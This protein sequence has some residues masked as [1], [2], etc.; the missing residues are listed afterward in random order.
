ML[1]NNYEY[2]AIAVDLRRP[3][4]VDWDAHAAN[5]LDGNI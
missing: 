2:E 1:Y 3:Q 5:L 4:Q